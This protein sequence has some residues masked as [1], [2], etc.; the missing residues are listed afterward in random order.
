MHSSLAR[1]CN[2]GCTVYLTTFP[3]LPGTRGVAGQILRLA[4]AADMN[5]TTIFMTRAQKPRYQLRDMWFSRYATDGRFG[6]EE[7]GFIA[8]DVHGMLIIL[9]RH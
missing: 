5:L 2:L 7:P 1:V 3:T 6:L 8:Q 9:G 4:L